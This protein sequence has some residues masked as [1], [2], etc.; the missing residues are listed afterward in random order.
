MN[1]LPVRQ[2]L[3]FEV[4]CDGLIVNHK[5]D[6]RRINIQFRLGDIVNFVE[7]QQRMSQMVK[8]ARKQHNIKDAVDGWVQV[9]HTGS[10]IAAILNF[11]QI[12][13]FIISGHLWIIWTKRDK[14]GSAAPQALKAEEAVPWRD[15]KDPLSPEDRGL[16]PLNRVIPKCPY[17]LPSCDQEISPRTDTC[18]SPQKMMEC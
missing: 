5:I 13:N 10:N 9:I 7:G 6:Y 1:E 8:D 11:Q 3:L 15:I 14:F 4:W 12:S 16:L 18:R 2:Y 17:V